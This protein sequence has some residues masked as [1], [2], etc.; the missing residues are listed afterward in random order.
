MDLSAI[1]SGSALII[2]GILMIMNHL[3]IWSVLWGLFLMGIG[4]V[5]ILYSDKADKIE[6][7]RRKK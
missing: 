3:E 1:F 5:I 2:I 7:I 6:G 4:I